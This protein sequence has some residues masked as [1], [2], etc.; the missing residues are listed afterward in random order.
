MIRLLFICA[1]NICRSPMAEAL[2][3]HLVTE[4]GLAGHFEIDSAGTGAWH[5]GELPHPETRA[6]L[7]QQKISYAGQRARQIQRADIE[8]YD[9]L[10]VMDS[11]NYQDVA[12]LARRSG[13]QRGE[14][15]RLLDFADPRVTGGER[16]LFDP[17]YQGGYDRVY[18][19]VR[20][21]CE[22]LLRH[23]RQ[24]EELPESA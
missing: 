11:D 20:S 24:K 2:F 10:V 8:H 4:A 21:A 19:F 17:Y 7:D 1:G 22:G 5:L 3:R 23:I 6:I 13:K 12:A 9:Y 15:V 18:T 14:L 16:D